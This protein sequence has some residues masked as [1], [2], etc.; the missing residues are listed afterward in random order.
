[1]AKCYQRRVRKER[2][3]E[4]EETKKGENVKVA[5]VENTLSLVQKAVYTYNNFVH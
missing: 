2:E 3:E 1:M 5:H 4:R